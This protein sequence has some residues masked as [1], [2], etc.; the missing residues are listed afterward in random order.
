MVAYYYNIKNDRDTALSY[1]DKILA[2]DPT[3]EVAKKNRDAINAATQKQKTKAEATTKE[4]VT[5]TK[6]KTKTKR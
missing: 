4:K 5:P 6:T 1:L 3:N 2:V